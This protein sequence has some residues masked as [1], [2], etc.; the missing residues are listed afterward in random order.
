MGFAV[1]DLGADT[2]AVSFVDAGRSADRLIGVGISATRSDNADGIAA[3]VTA[4][5]HDL[6]CPIVVGGQGVDADA[7]LALG[8]DEVTSSAAELIEVFGRLAGGQPPNVLTSPPPEEA[9][10]TPQ[11]NA[12]PNALPLAEP[13]DRLMELAIA[14]SWSRAGYAT[15]RILFRWDDEPAPRLD[16]RVVVLTGF[17]SGIGLAAAGRLAAEGAELHLV[18]RDPDKV[19]DRSAALR[20][21]GGRVTTSVADMS[22]LD[23]VRRLATEIEAAHDRVDVLAH[24]AGALA[25]SWTASAQGIETTVATQV[26]GPFLLTTLLRDR[27]RQAGPGARVLTMASGG[28]YTQRL[29]VDDLE[30]GPD[31]F[32]GARAYARAKRAQVEL[33]AEWARRGPASVAFHALHPGWADTPGVVASLPRFHALT[34]PI[35]RSP[36]EGA[37]TLAWLAAAPAAVG[38]SGGFWLDRRR[39]A[40]NKVPWTHPRTGERTRL[41]AWCE[42]RTGLTGDG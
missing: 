15:R 28:M 22:D 37:D 16:G 40:T 38:P 17:T 30:M 7:A 10:M 19:R 6:G 34:R 32:E 35:L 11:P 25:G 8:V 26:L 4:V 1:I 12:L 23:D 9:P 5:R 41:W 33:T 31:E 24:N 36:E 27:L 14:P 20:A 2:P 13:L 29:S 39:R 18:G 42:R 3:A 21:E